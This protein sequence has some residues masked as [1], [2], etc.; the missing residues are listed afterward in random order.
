MKYPLGVQVEVPSLRVCHEICCPFHK[1]DY[2]TAI[3]SKVDV[4][5]SATTNQICEILVCGLIGEVGEQDGSLLV[6]R[7]SWPCS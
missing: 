2:R 4:E 6:M 5:Q 1:R 7:K 3:I